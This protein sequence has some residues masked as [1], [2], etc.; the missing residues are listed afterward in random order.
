M[1]NIYVKAVVKKMVDNMEDLVVRAVTYFSSARRLDDAY[2]ELVKAEALLNS[3]EKYLSEQGYSVFTKRLSFPGLNPQLAEKIVEYLASSSLIVSVGYQRIGALSPETA[4]YLTGNGLYV[5]I[6]YSGED[7]LVFA[8][9]ACKIISKAAEQNPVNATRIALG[10]HSRDFTTPYYPD[11][12]ST[13]KVRI[14]LAFLYPKALINE[15]VKLG[16]IQ[17]AFEIMFA[18]IHHVTNLVEKHV[19]IP[20]K[21]DYSLSP[22]ME[23]SVAELFEKLGYSLLQPGSNYGIGLINKLI[24]K[25]MDKEKAVGFNEVMLPYAEDSLLIKYGSEKLLKARDFLRFASTCVAGVDMVV[26]PN[27]KQNLEKLIL[28]AYSIRL[29]KKKPLAF[30]AI[31]VPGSPGDSVELG[32]FGRPVILEY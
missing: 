15:M 31:P 1:P 30:R 10:F 24:R 22:W 28:D 3:V 19:G 8:E 13:S 16:D 32:K 14:A 17:A 2:N 6:L 5:P 18:R 23:N 26:I 27:E 4:V 29:V 25:Y 21:I 20:V 11:S 7:P 9:K 12:S